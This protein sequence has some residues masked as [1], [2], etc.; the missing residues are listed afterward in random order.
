MAMG[1]MEGMLRRMLSLS[2][3]AF[4][5]T[6]GKSPRKAVPQRSRDRVA[7]SMLWFRLRATMKL[8]DQMTV[9]PRAYRAP[10]REG[11]M[12]MELQATG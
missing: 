3:Q 5:Q 11:D 9:A 2:A 10:R 7:G 4:L 8:P 12:F 1:I 6:K